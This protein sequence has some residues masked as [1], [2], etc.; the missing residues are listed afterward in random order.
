MPLNQ[1]AEPFHADGSKVGVLLLH[2]FTGSPASMV[3]W[4]RAVADAGYTV[5]VPRLPGHGT[6]WQEC[7][8]TRWEDWYSEAEKSL[9]LLLDS[10]EQVFVFGLSM[11][12]ALAIR[13]AQ[14]RGDDVAGLVLVNPAVNSTN[15]QLVVLPLARKLVGSFP[16]LANDIAKPG[17][18]EVAYDRTPLQALYS[19]KQ[20]W[21]VLV[22][23]L[24]K[25]TM[26]LLMFRSNDDH[27]VD[28]SSGD[29]ILARVASRMVNEVRLE[30]SYHVATLDYDADTIVSGSLDFLDKHAMATDGS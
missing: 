26:P 15:K 12:G 29:L 2:G 13:L 17:Q 19:F 4:G 7:N 21:P 30:R 10:C 25:V 8:L 20:Q 23:D 22:A 1:G 27:V 5:D 18:D 24:P 9:D 14:Q 28:P 3:G 6:T 16:G 11:G